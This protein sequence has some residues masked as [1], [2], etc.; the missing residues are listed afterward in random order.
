MQ[1]EI[2]ALPQEIANLNYPAMI[3]FAQLF[4]VKQ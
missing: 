3:R 4:Q 1:E 2:F